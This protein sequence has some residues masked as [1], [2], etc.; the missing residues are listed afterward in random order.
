MKMIIVFVA[1][2]M[3]AQAMASVSAEKIEE[4]SKKATALGTHRANEMINAL[5]LARTGRPA[6]AVT[7]MKE[8]AAGRE[9]KY[10]QIRQALGTIKATEKDTCYY[11]VAAVTRDSDAAGFASA[12]RNSSIQNHD[13]FLSF[14]FIAL[15]NLSMSTS[16]S[17]NSALEE[18]IKTCK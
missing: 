6:F 16:E 18:A 10:E 5:S 13:A 3:S 1:A 14:E 15:V 2:F 7:E 11:S 8:A 9:T 4:I 12:L 17:M